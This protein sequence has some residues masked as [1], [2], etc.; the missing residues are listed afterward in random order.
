[1]P[2]QRYGL[3][4]LVLSVVF[5][6]AST[7]QGDEWDDLNITIDPS[8]PTDKDTI[9]LHACVGSRTAGTWAS[10]SPPA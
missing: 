3:G 10:I 7:S 4:L 8:S 1:M 5:T 2:W 9:D 6:V